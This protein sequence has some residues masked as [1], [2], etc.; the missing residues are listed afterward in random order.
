MSDRNIDLVRHAYDAVN[1][2]DVETVLSLSAPDIVWLPLRSATEGEFRGHDG[3]RKY[4]ADNAQIFDA[5][6]F[7]PHD[8]RD[9]GDDRVLFIGEVWVRGRGSGVETRS[10]SA[11][12]VWLRDGR[13]V[14]VEDFGTPERALEAVGL[15]D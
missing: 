9:L 2:G 13:A 4:F 7:E 11:S 5:F 12:V 6:G 3:I 10:P 1:R 8:F 15:P 14:R